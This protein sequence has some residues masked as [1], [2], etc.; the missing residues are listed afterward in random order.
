MYEILYVTERETGRP[1]KGQAGVCKEVQ[2]GVNRE[3][4]VGVCRKVQVQA[5]VC[6][7]ARDTGRGV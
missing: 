4:Q 3:I 6:R 7:D 2:A 5:E 1:E